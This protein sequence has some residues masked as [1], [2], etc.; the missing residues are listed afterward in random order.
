MPS[1]KR[2]LLALIPLFSGCQLLHSTPE[3]PKQQVV[4]MQGEISLQGSNWR[5]KPCQESRYFSLEETADST[6]L[7]DARQLQSQQP[8]T[9]FADLQ[10]DLQTAKD[11]QSEGNLLIT[12]SYRLQTADGQSGCSDPNFEHLVVQANAQDGQW[13]ISINSQGLLLNRPDQEPLAVP[14]IEEQLPDGRFDFS[15]QANGE[16]INLWIAPE[17]CVDAKQQ[18]IQSLSA[19]LNLNGQLTQGCAYFGGARNLPAAAP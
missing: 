10:G 6:V 14:Y 9:L 4:R 5:F 19:T 17:R 12:K 8:G 2:L 1:P 11:S 13:S 3:A 15:T 16:S 18:R 7:E